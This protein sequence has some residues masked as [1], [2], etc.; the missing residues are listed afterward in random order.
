MAPAAEVS[1]R[2]DD[3]P[4]QALHDAMRLLLGRGNVLRHADERGSLELA[5]ASGQGRS[6]NLP[7]AR[8]DSA[9]GSLLLALEREE[10]ASPLGDLHWQDY[11]GDARLLAW[12]LAHEILIDMLGQIF[13]G[14][15]LSGALLTGPAEPA[16]CWLALSFK[17]A[18]G[19]SRQGWIG[20][21]AHE[22]RQLASRPQWQRDPSRLAVMG[23]VSTLQLE[24]SLAGRTLEPAAIA[25]LD[26]GDV[27][28][29]GDAAE[30]LGRLQPDAPSARA[31]FGLPDAWTVQRRDGQWSIAA[32]PLIDSGEPAQ[33]PRFVLT[34]LSMKLEHVAALQTGSAVAYD[35]P[36]LDSA[37]DL[38][39]RTPIRS[40]RC[41]RAGRMAG[42]THHPQGSR[43]W[44][45]VA[46]RLRW[47]SPWSWRWRWRRL[48]Q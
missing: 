38:F 15:L 46:S 1:T 39:W 16:R 30:C 19:G 23:E 31:V 43:A 48:L 33:R 28:L 14:A 29:I 6:A 12:S 37:G 20:L 17:D 32:R 44:I 3:T 9:Q 27:L 10:G 40:G 47:S 4:E 21:G 24:L 35:E 8:L 2:R 25:R 5:A 45:S 41:R 11:E 26:T 13:G 42:R 7:T 34:H 36:L 22:A 18:E